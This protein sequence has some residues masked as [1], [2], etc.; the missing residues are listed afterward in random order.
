VDD[1][2]QPWA[3]SGSPVEARE[4]K[5]ESLLLSRC[6]A[7]TEA[8]LERWSLATSAVE[9]NEEEATAAARPR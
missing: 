8:R 5:E 9:R 3:V 4:E 2:V 7:W 6:A 1:G